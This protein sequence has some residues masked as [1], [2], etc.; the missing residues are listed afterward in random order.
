[1]EHGRVTTLQRSPRRGFLAHWQGREV[2]ARTVLLATGLVDESPDIEGL[3][4]A[5]YDGAI[6]FCPI[7]DGFEAMD[8]RIGVLGGGP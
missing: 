5:V 8:R 3:D 7:C 2:A 1:M 6:R 4:A